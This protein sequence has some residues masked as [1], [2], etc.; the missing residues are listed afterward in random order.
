MKGTFCPITIEIGFMNSDQSKQGNAKIA[1]FG[2]KRGLRP[3]L[4]NYLIRKTLTEYFE[5]LEF[6]YKNWLFRP[7]RSKINRFP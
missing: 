5:N 3:Y 6:S 2:Q 4:L 7:K 1:K